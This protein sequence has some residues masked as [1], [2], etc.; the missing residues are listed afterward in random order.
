MLKGKNV[1]LG[2]TGG[3]AAYKACE[4]ASALVKQHA[5][6]NVIM[7]KNATEFVA[8]LTFDALTHNRTVT[9]T[10]DRMHSYEIEHISLAEKADVIVIAPASANV[11]A[12]LANG[13]A[14]DMLTTTVLASRAVKLIA[15]AMN[16]NM[17][18]NPVTQHNLEVLKG[19]GWEIIG[20]DSGRLACGTTGRGKMV[21]PERL[22]DAVEHA[23]AHEKDMAGVK[24]MVTAGPT[25]EAVDPVRY[26][27]NHSS[28]KMGYAIATAAA[29]RG[30]EVTLVSGRTGLDRPG[31]MEVVD[32]VS[33]GD[34]YEAVTA[35]AEGMD[36]IVKAAAVADF[37]PAVCAE[38]KIK[39]TGTEEGA[40]IALERTEDILAWLG[41]HKGAEQVLCGFSMETKDMLENSR[42]KLTKKNLDII[43]ANNLKEAGAGFRVDTNLLTLIRPEEEKVLPLMTKYEAA[44][45]LLDELMRIRKEKQSL[46]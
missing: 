7:T 24:L 44:N 16:T 28:G 23:I 32:V 3:I 13:L 5:D 19:Y 18:E 11:I 14:D 42:R 2:V 37:R 6:V 43:A 27:T 4:L 26:L 41:A 20:P 39:K 46:R 12:K 25:Q 35:R 21:S 40:A 17:Y 34:M 45:V 1:L 15:P 30:A 38:D 22:L 9:D 10:F 36:M 33:A 8:P 29:R 31:Y